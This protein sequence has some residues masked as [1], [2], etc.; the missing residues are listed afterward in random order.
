MVR[1]TVDANIDVLIH[2]TVDTIVNVVMGIA[3]D[4]MVE[5]VNVSFDFIVCN[6]VS[7]PLLSITAIQMAIV[8]HMFFLLSK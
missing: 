5:L 1:A 7:H 3:Y 6:I 4:P 2:S 8:I